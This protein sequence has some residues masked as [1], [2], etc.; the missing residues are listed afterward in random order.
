MPPL[1]ELRAV[2]CAFGGLRALD[3]VS[4]EVAE[5][6]ILGLIGP[7]GAGKTTLLNVVAGVQPPTFGSVR[8]AGRTVPRFTPEALC[9]S[10]VSRTF[11]IPRAFPS[12]TALEN[13]RVAA[14]FGRHG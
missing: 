3:R 10:G 1:L 11:Q 13:V 7:N 12:L 14:E 8:L 9:R 5:G 4:L 2:T 6:E